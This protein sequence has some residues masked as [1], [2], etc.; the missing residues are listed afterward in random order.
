MGQE[1]KHGGV[2]PNSGRKPLTEEQKQAKAEAQ[3][4]IILDELIFPALVT[5]MKA[6]PDKYG[7]RRLEVEL[8]KDHIFLAYGKEGLEEWMSYF[9]LIKIG[10]CDRNGESMKTRW[11]M[12]QNKY[13]VFVKMLSVFGHTP[14]DLPEVWFPPKAIMDRVNAIME[15]RA[16]KRAAKFEK[17]LKALG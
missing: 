3:R 2:R 17:E 7:E 16:A 12:N 13:G 6:E 10:G 5:A 1:K 11:G 15:R 9:R 14:K 8:S 4:K